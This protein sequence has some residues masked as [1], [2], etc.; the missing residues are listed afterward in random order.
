MIPMIKGA[1]VEH[2]RSVEQR[3]P[4]QYQH[5]D[6]RGTAPLPLVYIDLGH[7][8]LMPDTPVLWRSGGM[9]YAPRIRVSIS[10]VSRER[11]GCAR[12]RSSS[13]LIM[14]WRSAS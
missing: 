1:A 12:M 6:R 2:R 3:G 5:E 13:V 11:S 8:V 4:D 9:C 14:A 7:L 10:V